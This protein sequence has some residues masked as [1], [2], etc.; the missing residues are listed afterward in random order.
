MSQVE[1]YESYIELAVDVF[2]AQNQELIK[3]LKDFLTILPSPTYIE[4]VLIAGIG[5]LAETEPEVCRWL[6]RNYS[7]LMPEVDLVDLAIDLAITKLES[8]G[9]VLDQ[10]FGWNTNGQLYISEQAKA[11]LL[12]GNSFRDRLLVE[13]VLLVGD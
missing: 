5:R 3:F 4:Q 8:Q 1:A 7:Y 11:I 10:D 2:K 9:F 12:E 6:L 13:E